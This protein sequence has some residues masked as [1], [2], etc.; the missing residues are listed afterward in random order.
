M[1]MNGIF[2]IVTGAAGH[3]G[4]HVVHELLKS[5]CRVRALLLPNESV[6]RFINLNTALLSVYHGNV[7]D[8]AS[9]VPLFA[10]EPGEE[11]VVIHCAG[12]VSITSIRN[13]RV[14]DVNVGGTANVIAACRKHG[15]KRLVYVSSVHAIPLLPKGKVMQEV[16]RF[17]PHAVVGW[18]AK[19]KATA[20]QLVLD[21]AKQGLNAVVVHPSGI[22]GPHGLPTGNMVE[23][24]TSFLNGKFF[25]GIR[26]GYDFVDVRDV[27]DGIIAAADKGKSGEC[28]ILSNRYVTLKEMLGTLSELSGRKKVRVYLPLWIARTF[29]PFAELHYRVWRRTPLFTIYSLHTISHNSLFSH[30]KASRELGYRTRPLR[31]TLADTTRSVQ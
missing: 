27:A 12:I 1:D 6:P 20:T 17:S 11:A 26:G 8:Q 22:I 3:L 23:L 15:V 31:E 25:A 19:T 14:Y 4:S 10:C 7:C 13:K 30:A 18:Y 21:A 24:I 29:A 28:Y 9:L 16:N 2:Y 5:N